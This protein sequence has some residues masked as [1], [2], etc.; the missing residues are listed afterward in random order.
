MDH[1][2]VIWLVSSVLSAL[3]LGNIWFV[4][5]LVDKLDALDTTVNRSLPVQQSEM[6]SMMDKINRLDININSLVEVRER[7][8]VLEYANR[9]K[10]EL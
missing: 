10:K 5:R 3:F 1:G 9:I 7:V 8:A 4:K 2:T 6:K